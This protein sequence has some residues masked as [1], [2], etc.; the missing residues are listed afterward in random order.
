[1]RVLNKTAVV[2]GAASGLGKATCVRLAE[3]GAK[4]AILDL[5]ETGSQQVCAEIQAK[6]KDCLSV[7]ADVSQRDEVFAAIARIADHFG[8][9]D[10][11]VNSAGI[12]VPGTTE[13]VTEELWNRTIDV[14]LR[15]TFWCAQAVAPHMKRQGYGKIVNFTSRHVLGSPISRPHYA[16]S[17]GGIVALTR[18]LAMELAPYGIN[19]NAVGPGLMDTPLGHHLDRDQLEAIV[20]GIPL[21]RIGHPLDVANAVLFLVSDEASYIT[22]QVLYICGGRSLG[23]AL[24]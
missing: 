7:K 8:R 20:R 15:G 4:T 13:Q 12:S 6:Q 1:M 22:G 17:K 18:D 19:V 5:D 21:G 23:Q 3:E 14:N 2:T 10:I 24:M 16:S 9:I 11:L